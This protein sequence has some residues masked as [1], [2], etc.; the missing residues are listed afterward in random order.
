MRAL[1]VPT[2]SE[3]KINASYIKVTHQCKSILSE[4]KRKEKKR[5]ENSNDYMQ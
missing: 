5:K 4:A 3:Q 2:V 1:S